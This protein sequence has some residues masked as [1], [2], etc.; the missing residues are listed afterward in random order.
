AGAFDY[1]V[2]F[3]IMGEP[4]LQTIP[5]GEN[6]RDIPW[7]MRCDAAFSDPALQYC[8]PDMQRV[9]EMF[10]EIATGAIRERATE[11]ISERLRGLFPGREEPAATDEASTEQ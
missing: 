9:S 1:R 11:V 7:P 5:I 2:A 3:T 8:S 10:A 4:E 6:Y